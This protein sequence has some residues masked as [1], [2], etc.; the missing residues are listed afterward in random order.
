MY[1]HDDK[2]MLVCIIRKSQLAD[3]NRILSHY[4]DTFAY[5]TNTSEVM[6]NGFSR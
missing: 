4:P 5:I 3:F 1:S 2:F 6:G